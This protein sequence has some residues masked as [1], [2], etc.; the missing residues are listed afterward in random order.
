MRKLNK[1]ISQ[2][3]AGAF[4]SPLV[5]HSLSALPQLLDRFYTTHPLSTLILAAIRPIP[6]GVEWMEKVGKDDEM[7]TGDFIQGGFYGGS[8]DAVTWWEKETARTTEWQGGLNR[9]AVSSFSIL[10][11]TRLKNPYTAQG[12]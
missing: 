2:V 5:S 9:C 7:E 1:S 4:R 8:F 11:P 3:D 10:R 12:N 6:S